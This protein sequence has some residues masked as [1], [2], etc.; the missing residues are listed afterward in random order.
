M[1]QVIAN[2]LSVCR[3][4]INFF[5]LHASIRSSC[6]NLIVIS[7]GLIVEKMI[8]M[9]YLKPLKLYQELLK[10]NE[11]KRG[12]LL[13]LDVGYK[14]V[15]LSVSDANNKIASPLRLMLPDLFVS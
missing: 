2:I 11:V 14:Y 1:F 15:G 9:K 12:R 3:I 5:K 10:S 13:G 8:Q 6:V 4:L 7:L